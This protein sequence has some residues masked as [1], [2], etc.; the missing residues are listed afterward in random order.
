[1][2]TLGYHLKMCRKVYGEDSRATVYMR[3]RCLT[4]GIDTESPVPDHQIVMLCM[5]L[6]YDFSRVDAFKEIKWIP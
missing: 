4:L 6:H 5:A 1:M 2:A 3:E